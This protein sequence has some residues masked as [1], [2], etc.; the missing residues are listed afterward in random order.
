MY[1]ITLEDFN[2]MH[3]FSYMNYILH[4]TYEAHFSANYIIIKKKYVPLK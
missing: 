4:N 2:I 1:Q 3:C